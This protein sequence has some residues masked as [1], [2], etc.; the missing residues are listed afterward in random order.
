MREFEN[1]VAVVT[2][3]ASGIGRAM[4]ETLI[5]AGMKVVLADVDEQR[6][7]ITVKELKDN[8]ATVLGVAADVSKADQVSALADKAV[9]AFG[10]VHVLCNNAGVTCTRPN[11]WDIPL[12]AWQWVLGVNLMGVVHGIQS[13]LPI[14]LEQGVEGHIV[15]TASLAGLFNE[16]MNTPYCVS[17]H[18]VVTLSENLYMELQSKN[19]KIN[20]SVLCPGPVNTNIEQSVQ[21]NRPENVPPPPE[22]SAEY[23]VFVKAFRLWIM[24]GLDPLEVGRQVLDAIKKEQFYIITHDV[25]DPYIKARMQTILARQN[26]V[27]MPPPEELI[28]IVNELMSSSA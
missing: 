11:S 25:A 27:Q 22:I 18:A 15:N 2:G 4:S 13:F 12:A 5:H 3:A 19:A 9:Q 21:R 16:V 20:V 17:K 23:E 6:L 10:A 24:R 7:D 1:R 28:S 26:P 14:M 8:G